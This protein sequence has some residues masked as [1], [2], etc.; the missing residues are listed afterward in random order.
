PSFRAGDRNRY[1]ITRRNVL[2]GEQCRILI[3]CFE[4]RRDEHSVK[5]AGAYWN[6]RYIWQANLP[7]SEIDAIRILQ[8]LRFL[9]LSLL[10]QSLPGTDPL[11]SDSAQIVR[12]DPGIEL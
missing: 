11:F 1:F 10:M 8:Q 5:S 7:P 6:G 12:W 2:S 9:C 4:R 3:G